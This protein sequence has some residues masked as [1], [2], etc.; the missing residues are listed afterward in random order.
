MWLNSDPRVS[1][2]MLSAYVQR[3]FLDQH[4]FLG[5]HQERYEIVT[6]CRK[7]LTAILSND[8]AKTR[9][10]FSSTRLLL[11]SSSEIYSKWPQY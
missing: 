11:N 6:H 1:I 8:Q 4:S 7:G 3:T 10:F 2:T 9:F 5:V